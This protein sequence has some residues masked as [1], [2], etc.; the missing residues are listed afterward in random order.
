M[1]K[2]TINTASVKVMRSHDYCHF[3]V[4]L[5]ANVDCPPDSP[6]WFQQVDNLRKNA[7]RLA[8]KA[9]EQY[10]IAKSNQQI[11]EMN[12]QQAK[13][14]KQEADAIGDKPETE[15]TPDEQAVLKTYKDRLYAANR[16]YDYQDD[17]DD[18]DS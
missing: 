10:K 3:E 14:T 17:W 5:A 18:Q 6:E 16:E 13:Y 9:V 1:S 12:A 7:A 8:D 2:L 15:R 4:I 11:R